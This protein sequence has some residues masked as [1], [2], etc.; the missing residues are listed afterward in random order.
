MAQWRMVLYHTHSRPESVNLILHE[1]RKQREMSVHIQNC[2][3][4]C[5][6]DSTFNASVPGRKSLSQRRKDRRKEA[7]REK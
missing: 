6:G 2:Q 7:V 5:S 3:P 1:R 4:L